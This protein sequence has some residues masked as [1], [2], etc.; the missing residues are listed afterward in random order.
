MAMDTRLEKIPNSILEVNTTPQA[1]HKERHGKG[2]EYYKEVTYDENGNML[3]NGK[4]ARE[5]ISISRATCNFAGAYPYLFDV[6]SYVCTHYK[7]IISETENYYSIAM[8][9][10][11]FLEFALDG[12]K[13]QIQYLQNELARQEEKRQN[14]LIALTE[15]STLYAQPIIIAYKRGDI[16][17]RIITE[18]GKR[19]AEQ[20]GVETHDII[21]ILWVKCLT[22]DIMENDNKY[23][24][25]PKAFF[26]KLKSVETFFNKKE[27][28]VKQQISSMSKKEFEETYKVSVRQTEQEYK[29][30]LTEITNC[31]KKYV[32]AEVIYKFYNYFRLHDNSGEFTRLKGL[33]LLKHCA[34]QYI[35]THIDKQGNSIDYYKNRERAMEFLDLLVDTFAAMVKTGIFNVPETP[36]KN[37]IT[38]I[39]RVPS[40]DI[41]IYY[42]HRKNDIETEKIEKVATK[43]AY[44]V[45]EKHTKIEH[46]QSVINVPP[47][48]KQT[49][50]IAEITSQTKAPTRA[51]QI[52]A[53]KQAHPQASNRAI[54][55]VFKCNEI[56]VRR[57][58]S[59]Q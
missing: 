4:I 29:K 2:V 9:Y 49:E 41:K 53:Y 23:K 22:R 8:T 48:I 24:D 54:A 1:I 25:L 12:F 58:L 30:I 34:P 59:K 20:L 35:Q 31:E 14:K 17:K 50:N 16:S 47:Q 6:I 18:K 13:E 21:E 45:I 3:F 28:E 39:Q 27:L 37:L 44:K 57:A 11:K 10:N 36:M 26:A 40:G 5:K 55:E 42:D 15:E 33:D 56:T 19:G 52:I 32:T 51:E 46:Q 38:R 7:D 43:A